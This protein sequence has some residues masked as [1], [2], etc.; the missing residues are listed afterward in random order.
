MTSRSTPSLSF[1]HRCREV[2][3]F[4][5]TIPGLPSESRTSREC[6]GSSLWPQVQVAISLS[7]II[8]TLASGIGSCCAGNERADE[9]RKCGE[10]GDLSG[11]LATGVRHLPRLRFRC[12]HASNDV[13]PS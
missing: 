6:S 13:K 4:R 8:V 1:I 11:G 9:H 3:E 12:L 5:Q 7:S 2:L 10:D